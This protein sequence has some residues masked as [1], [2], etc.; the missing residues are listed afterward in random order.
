LKASWLTDFPALFHLKTSTLIVNRQVLFATNALCRATSQIY[1]GTDQLCFASLQV[2][3]DSKQARRFRE[4]SRLKCPVSLLCDGA[5]LQN[6]C[7]TLHL[8]DGNQQRLVVN[9]RCHR[10]H[11]LKCKV[12][13]QRHKSIL[14]ATS[15]IHQNRQKSL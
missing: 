3:G 9:L 4:P 6:D 1:V 7:T 5:S 8:H 12:T 15:T 13:K 14:Q 2:V 11:L 10:L